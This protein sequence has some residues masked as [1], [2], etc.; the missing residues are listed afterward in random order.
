MKRNKLFTKHH[1]LHLLVFN[2]RLD[3]YREYIEYAQ[4]HNYKVVSLEDF[5]SNSERN[6][7]KHF[8]LRH[9]VDWPGQSTRKMFELEKDLGVKSTYYFRFSTIDK[10]LID[11]MI[12][13]G[14][15][16]GLHFETIADYVKE[17]HISE[18]SCLDM[19]LMTDLLKKDI[20]RFEEIVCHKVHSICSHGAP[21]N[22]LL[23]VAN[24]TITERLLKAG[25]GYE[26][27]NIDFEAYDSTM[28][29]DV[30]CHIMDGGVLGHYGFSYK[31]TPISAI[32]EGKNNIVFLSHPSHWWLTPQDRYKSILL[33]FL[34][35]AK[36]TTNRK[37]KRN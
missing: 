27:L 18:A 16:V 19:D 3:D 8:V 32:D 26:L 31:D 37:F 6:Q 7:E 14:F 9:D 12:A 21:E 33:F 24:N 5:Y 25:G 17:H 15:D 29:N 10:P 4:K 30:D 1:V 28:Y 20:L 36:F 34:G 2:D 22:V 23:K 35:K 13:A 11:E